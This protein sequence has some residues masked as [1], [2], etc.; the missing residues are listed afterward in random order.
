[1]AFFRLRRSPLAH[2]IDRFH[3]LEPRSAPRHF[4][5]RAVKG[6]SEAAKEGTRSSDLTIAVLGITLGLIC[7][8]F[9]WYIFF[10]Q[11]KFGVRAMRFQGGGAPVTGSVAVGPPPQRVGAPMKVVDVPVMQLDLFA[12]GT[13]PDKKGD[14]DGSEASAPGLDKQPFPAEVQQFKLVHVANGRAM[15]E[16]D[17]GL[18][19]VQT[20][21]VLPDSSRVAS[22]EQR[23]GGWVLVTSDDRIVELTP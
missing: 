12:T 20:G 6:S 15:I 3:V 10:N 5:N 2:E 4:W 19:I 7:A 22:I 8:L 16:D 21:S 13:L 17:A 18:W 11:E 14:G 23:D 9:P 1:M